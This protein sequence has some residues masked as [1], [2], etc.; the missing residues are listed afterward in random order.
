MGQGERSRTAVVR[1]SLGK[2]DI[3]IMEEV[4]RPSQV[5]ETD[6]WSRAED[7]KK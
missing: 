6:R 7:G 1:M 4:K 2:E 5:D 3:S